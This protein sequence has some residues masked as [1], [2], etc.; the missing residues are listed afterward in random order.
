MADLK[1][2]GTISTIL[3]HGSLQ[4]KVIITSGESGQEKLKKI[5]NNV[6]GLGWNPHTDTIYVKFNVN[7]SQKGK[8]KEFLGPDLTEESL[9]WVDK[10]LLTR[11][12]LLSVINGI[13]DPLGLVTPVTI[14]LKVD[15]RNLFKCDPA[16]NWDD[17]NLNPSFF[18]E[19]QD[20]MLV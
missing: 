20:H 7:L 12:K 16:L 4:L 3:L 14:R 8:D 13:Y 19:Q 18:Q 1:C 10:R 2:D 6:L 17:P 5:G 9:L 15:F 11:R